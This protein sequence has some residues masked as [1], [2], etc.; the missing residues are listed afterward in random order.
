MYYVI[1]AVAAV[2][3]A[4]WHGAEVFGHSDRWVVYSTLFGLITFGGGLGGITQDIPWND[5]SYRVIPPEEASNT[6]TSRFL[7]SLSMFIGVC[8]LGFALY[9]H[10]SQ[11]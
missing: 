5:S 7:M 1:G 8:L 10:L 11:G 3:L 4:L 2:V 6:R 9:R